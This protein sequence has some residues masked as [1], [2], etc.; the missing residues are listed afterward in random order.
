[1]ISAGSVRI[2][3]LALFSCAMAA[4]VRADKIDPALHG[5]WNMDVAHSDFGPN[6]KPRSGQ[7]NL[8]AHGFSLALVFANGELFTDA[9]ATDGGCAYVGASPLTCASSILATYA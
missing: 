4:P 7:V 9:V 3:A 8:G 6:G 2:A 5:I 1:M